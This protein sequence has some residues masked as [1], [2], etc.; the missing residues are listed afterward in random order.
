VFVTI[1]VWC[2]CCVRRSTLN[3]EQC[4]SYRSVVVSNFCSS[5]DGGGGGGGI[6]GGSSSVILV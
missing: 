5:S 6:G 2:K 1:S 3:T 4:S